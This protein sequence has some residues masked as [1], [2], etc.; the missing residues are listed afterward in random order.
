MPE[1]DEERTDAKHGDVPA[2]DQVGW[3]WDDFPGLRRGL[4]GGAVGALI[5][6]MTGDGMGPRNY[7]GMAAVLC[8]AAGAVLGIVVG[9]VVDVVKTA[10]RKSA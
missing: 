9:F 1:P 2:K 8:G 7:R 5:G 6:A 4:I 10:G 3:R